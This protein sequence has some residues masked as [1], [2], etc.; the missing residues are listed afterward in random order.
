MYAYSEFT[1]MLTR[2][3]RE[4]NN[5]MTFLSLC[6]GFEQSCVADDLLITNLGADGV[7]FDLT[8]AFVF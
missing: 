6:F 4:E 5:A 8:G 1:N 3:G 7:A 2:F